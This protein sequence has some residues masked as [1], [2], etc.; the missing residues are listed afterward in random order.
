[1]STSIEKL[2][3]LDASWL[4]FETEDVPL[5]VAGGFDGKRDRLRKR[6]FAPSPTKDGAAKPR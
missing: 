6:G 3:G 4:H 2:S 5:H 1:M